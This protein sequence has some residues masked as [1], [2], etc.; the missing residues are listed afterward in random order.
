MTLMLKQPGAFRGLLPAAANASM[1]FR[2]PLKG[3]I[4]VTVRDLSGY[5]NIEASI[6]VIGLRVEGCKLIMQVTPKT[7]V[8]TPMLITH[9]TASV[10]Q[11]IAVSADTSYS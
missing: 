1:M 8:A 6:V 9:E 10:L 7:V 5:H 3:S 11:C 2:V 4:R